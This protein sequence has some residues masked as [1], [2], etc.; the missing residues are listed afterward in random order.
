MVYI[1]RIRVCYKALIAI[2]VCFWVSGSN[3]EKNEYDVVYDDWSYYKLCRGEQDVFACYDDK[4]KNECTQQE[5][6][7]Y[8]AFC[9]ND[10]YCGYCRCQSER[11]T[12][13][14]KTDDHG[15][16]TAAG[17]KSDEEIIIESGNYPSKLLGTCILKRHNASSQDRR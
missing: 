7:K 16:I 6:E 4:S 10:T 5:C 17:C 11:S 14:Y 2:I 1:R 12:F 9:L 13:T 15:N 3:G 8:N